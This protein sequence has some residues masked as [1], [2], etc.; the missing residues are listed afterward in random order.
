[1]HRIRVSYTIDITRT[2]GKSKIDQLHAR[3]PGLE[4]GR[5]TFACGVSD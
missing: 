5:A 1:M 4:L 3:Y 2:H